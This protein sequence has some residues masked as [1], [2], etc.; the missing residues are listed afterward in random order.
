MLV[1]LLKT[2]EP[3]REYVGGISAGDSPI[4]LTL[5]IAL[6]SVTSF[7][8]A[9]LLGPVAIGFLRRRF[10]ER[11]RSASSTLNAL[12]EHKNDTPTM[13]GIF[14]VASVFVATIFWGNWENRFVLLSTCVVGSYG[15]LGVI[16]DAVKLRTE[17]RG[18]SVRQKFLGQLA[19][20]LFW[21]VLL[22]FEQ[23]RQPLG[24]ALVWPVGNVVWPLGLLF[25]GWSVL[26]IVATANAVNLTDGMDG[27]AA[28]CTV[29]SA[30]AYTVLC[31]LAG[32]RVLAEYLA[33]PYIP[34]SGEMA[35][36][37]GAL[38]GAMLGFLWFNA[39]PADVFLGDAGSLPI[40]AM[41][42]V[43]ALTIHQ[44][45][46]LPVIGGVFVAETLSVI[47]QVAS[48]RLTGR[49]IFACSPL[50]HH[51][52]FRGLPET[53]IVVRFWIVSAVLA[54]AGLASLKVR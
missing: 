36:V 38:A 3:L 5:R 14:V 2:W 15:V 37:L 16:D 18:L 41:L 40:G 6:A 27:L 48:F 17:R 32:H 45:L 22:Y 44:E 9:L 7:L 47:L 20:A 19:M 21:S 13:G 54:V 49:R 29:T 11:V 52:L 42:A 31:Y 23:Q 46:L 24:L 39:H 12:H 33:I 26:L 35:V 30:A 10:P 8:A 34:G 53:K 4:L 51:F 25:I 1:W 28:G 50:H 43:A